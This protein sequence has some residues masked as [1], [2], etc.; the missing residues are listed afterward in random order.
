MLKI[1]QIFI[2]GLLL[3]LTM[4]GCAKSDA[5]EKNTDTDQIALADLLVTSASDIVVIGETEQNK[6]VALFED[7]TTEDVTTK[8]TWTTSDQN[9][10][11]VN[12]EGLVT[13]QDEGN[14]TITASYTVNGVT[15]TSENKMQVFA[16]APVFVSAEIHGDDFLSAQFSTELDAYA[17][18][19]DNSV[20]HVDDRVDWES[21]DTSIATVNANGV[22]TGLSEGNVTIT[23]KGKLDPSKT[24]THIMSIGKI[25][26][27]TIVANNIIWDFDDKLVLE[28]NK[29][30][31]KGR[32][33]NN[34]KP[35]YYGVWYFHEVG[36]GFEKDQTVAE[37]YFS[38]EA[39][40]N[41]TTDAVLVDVYVN[42]GTE[43]QTV[44]IGV[45]LDADALR[46]PTW[47]DF[48][49]DHPDWT[50]RTNYVE[51]GEGRL[52]HGNF[53][54]RLGHSGSTLSEDFV[55]SKF[56][57][58]KV[59]EA[60]MIVKDNIVRTT[61][62]ILITNGGLSAQSATTGQDVW[63]YAEVGNGFVEG[64]KVSATSFQFTAS[65]DDTS[66]VYVNVY[67]NDGTVG[68]NHTVTLGFADDPT[69][70]QFL[71][72]DEV[73]AKY[74]NSTLRNYWETPTPGK[75]IR[76]NFY[77]RIGDSTYT[78]SAPFK[79]DKFIVAFR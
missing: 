33:G 53:F 20:H 10:A 47:G 40:K 44:K 42:D 25:P 76:G 48:K 8:A 31:A 63:Y 60:G 61:A 14:V 64:Q 70:D 35:K 34:T 66:K 79:I 26:T 9:I 74:P 54:L 16:S 21:N 4:T 1:F 49:A 39:T 38:F 6:A 65:S 5:T 23:I 77:L 45:P 19:S 2:A 73:I 78:G 30:V 27:G 50:I 62:D 37:T 28:D 57:V 69:N 46:Y 51:R 12:N 32:T 11:V 41:G 15:K 67:L 55:I 68:G 58:V 17:T 29:T 59:P 36:Y 52:L 3:S 22:V 13:G 56:I 24:A 71:T 7:G 75:R 43:N 72:W 18:L